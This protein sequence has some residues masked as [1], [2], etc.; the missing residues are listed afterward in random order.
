MVSQSCNRPTLWATELIFV[1]IGPAALGT[2]SSKLELNMPGGRGFN[3]GGGLINSSFTALVT[4]SG[5]ILLSKVKS[6]FVWDEEEIE[7]IIN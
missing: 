1:V 5:T 6:S 3:L 7:A 4:F 2:P